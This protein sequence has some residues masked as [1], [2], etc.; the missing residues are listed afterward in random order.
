[1]YLNIGVGSLERAFICE[2]NS[3]YKSNC[4]IRSPI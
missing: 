2:T 1:M 3:D 4:A